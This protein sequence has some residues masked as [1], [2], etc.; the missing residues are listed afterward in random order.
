MPFSDHHISADHDET[1]TYELQILISLMEAEAIRGISGHV[2]R[3]GF[4]GSTGEHTA[5]QN[6]P[7]RKPNIASKSFLR[8]RQGDGLSIK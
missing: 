2:I 5:T 3:C 1:V 7:L 4:C 8:Q 6:Q